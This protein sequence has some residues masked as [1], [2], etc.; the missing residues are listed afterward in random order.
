M[1]IRGQINCGTNKP[2]L[3]SNR[4]LFSRS[5]CLTR[6]SFH[7]SIIT[8]AH[9]WSTCTGSL[10]SSHHPSISPECALFG[11]FDVPPRV[12]LFFQLTDVCTETSVVGDLQ[13]LVLGDGG[14]SGMTKEG[15]GR[16]LPT[17]LTKPDVVFSR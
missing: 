11:L 14:A 16:P 5:W 7:S 13:L 3:S 9:A 6:G 12:K 1:P 17:P 2:L 4:N 10:G 15:A 8:G